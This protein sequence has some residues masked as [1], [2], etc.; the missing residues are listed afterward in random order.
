MIHLWRPLSRLYWVMQTAALFYFDGE[1][2]EGSCKEGYSKNTKLPHPNFLL[3]Q[4]PKLLGTV[5]F[6]EN[7]QICILLFQRPA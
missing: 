4:G 5:I 7:S 3:P 1:K 6:S 2:E